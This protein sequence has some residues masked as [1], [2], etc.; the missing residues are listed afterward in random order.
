ME[1]VT[2]QSD[3]PTAAVK[4]AVAWAGGFIGIQLSDWVLLATLIYTLLQI[5]FLLRDKW[6]R[7]KN[8]SP[9]N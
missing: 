4:V 2:E 7:R 5:Y 1:A 3:T 8:E 6:R 9:E